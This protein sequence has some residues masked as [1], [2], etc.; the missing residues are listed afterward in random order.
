MSQWAYTPEQ[1]RALDRIA[2]EEQGIPGYELMQR[3]G[4]VAFNA[5]REAFPGADNWLIFCGSGNN[6]GDGYVVA[7]LALAAGL[8]VRVVAVSDPTGLQGDAATAYDDF[9]A[10]GG[11]AES[12]DCAGTITEGAGLCV[13]ALLGTGLQRSVEGAY[14]AAVTTINDSGLPVLAIDIPSGLHGAS[15]AVQGVAVRADLTATFVGLKQGL[16]LGAGPDCC[17]RV[18]Y[19]DLGIAPVDPERVT[20]Q[21]HC[22]GT[23][24]LRRMLPARARGGHKGRYGHVLVIGGNHGMGGAVRLAGEAAL[25]S[26]AGLVSVATRPDN[27]G[28]VVA[29]RPEL[30]CRGVAEAGQLDALLARA[31]L[32]AVGPGLGSDDW[33]RE[34]LGR[35][36]STRLPLVVDADALNLLAADPVTR[37]N[38]ALTP[39]PGEAGRML[40]MTAAEVQADRVGALNA[41][42]ARY[43]GTILLKGAGTLVT[44]EPQPWLVRAGNPGMAS[45]GT[46][47]VLT[48]VT[49]AMLAQCS[50]ARPGDV[51]AAAAWVHASAGDRAALGGERG[52]MAG[53]VLSELRA[54][55]N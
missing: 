36:L 5:G 43:G 38:W 31:T 46:G 55:L 17:G 50:D 22:A 7:Q 11:R 27:V 35:V 3:A 24:L 20:P 12:A 25:R 44:S 45:A 54:C 19:S 23:E 34:L 15:G 29:G 41:L 37:D 30:M 14:A 10:A 40:G 33:A 9:L 52:L 26:G 4:Q 2:I 8:Q 39:H 53:D 42:Q 6:G 47:D 51:V 18:I 13:D 16:Y 32:I 49:A 1:V 28:A 21:L 48:G